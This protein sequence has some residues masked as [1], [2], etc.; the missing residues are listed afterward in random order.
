MHCC[1]VDQ[2][3]PRAIVNCLRRLRSADEYKAEKVHRFRTSWHVLHLAYSFWR[4]TETTKSTHS[5]L[6]TPGTYGWARRLQQLT[7]EMIQQ[8][9]VFCSFLHSGRY[10][11]ENPPTH[12]LYNVT[13]FWDF[14]IFYFC[15]FGSRNFRSDFLY[16]SLLTA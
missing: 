13:L 6:K 14:T 3:L 16:K 1:N 4:V 11:A 10:P 7:P 5:A 12:P 2:R 8:E 15:N 9:P